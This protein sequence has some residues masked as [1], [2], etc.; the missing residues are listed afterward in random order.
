MKMLSALLVV[1]VILGICTSSY[2]YFLVYNLSGTVRGTD[3]TVNIR[4]VTISFR[5]Y[6]VMT[7]DDDTNSFDDANLIIYGRDPNNNKVYIQLNASDSNAFLDSSI[8]YRDVKNFYELNGESPFDFRIVIQGNV[9][10]TNIG[11]AGKKNIAPNLRGVLTGEDGM[12]FEV[13]EEITGIGNNFSASLQTTSTK[14][15]NTPGDPCTPDEVI[16]E[17][18]GKLADKGYTALSIPAPTR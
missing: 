16:D 2:G 14:K 11:L 5:S 9:K 8:W 18:I 10:S 13:G 3:G 7:F 12:F 17:L 15:F 4:N 1:L 6:L